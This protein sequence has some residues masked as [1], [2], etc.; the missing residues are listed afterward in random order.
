MKKKVIIE[1]NIVDVIH[2]TITKGRLNIEGGRIISVEASDVPGDQYIFPG[3]IDAHVHIESSM[4][5]P[6]SFAATAVYH[7]T[8]ATVSDPHEIANVLGVEGVRFMIENGNTTPFKFNFGAPS[9]VP[10]TPF[11]TSGASI[12]AAE[13]ALLLA[14]PEVKYLAEMM[15]FPG[16][17]NNDKMVAAKLAAAKQFNKPVDGHAPC[18]RGALLKKYVDAGISTDH[19]CFDL[20]EAIEKASLGMQILI[21][22]G[23]AA[24]NFNDLIPLLNICPGQVMFCSDD[25]HPDDLLNGHINLLIKRALTLGYDL[26]DTI[27]AATLNPVKH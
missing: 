18:L 20:E 7:G 4:V 1:G 8:T 14:T 25:K 13:T 6:S 16:V 27:S 5:V 15:N 2:R 23:S 9:C 19:E 24:K 21:R 3:F 22:E 17:I 10:A 26:F 12:D 11:E